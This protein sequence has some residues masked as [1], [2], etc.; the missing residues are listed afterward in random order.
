MDLKHVIAE[1]RM[2]SRANVSDGLD[3]VGAN[4]CPHGIGPL[5]D[6]CPKIVWPS[7]HIEARS[8]GPGC[9]SW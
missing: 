9:V 3:R 4:G 2:L 8:S 1:Y 5:W 7:G 6:A